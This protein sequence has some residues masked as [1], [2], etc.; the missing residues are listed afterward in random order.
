MTFAVVNSGAAHV[1]LQTANG[2][3]SG[4]I[5][6]SSA[7]ILVAHAASYKPGT[8]T[9]SDSK[10]NTWTKLT[11]KTA[12][13]FSKSQIA[14]AFDHGGSALV[15]G[16]GHTFTIATDTPPTYCTFNAAAFSGSL[17][18]DPINAQNGLAQNS[19]GTTIAPGSVS[20]AG[21]DLFITG[22]CFE[23]AA[24]VTIGS[25]FTILDQAGYVASTAFAGA[26]AWKESSSAENP[27]WTMNTNPAFD[28]A[29]TIA[30]FKAAAGGGG[31]VGPLTGGGRLVHGSLIRGGGLAA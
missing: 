17:T 19:T 31:L 16:S 14:Y 11:A 2:G 5:D 22:I 1:T 12:N 6:T 29:A 4:A 13:T 7:S 20:P 18:T 9:F 28:S 21:T 27:T 30:S 24:S 10:G 23:T 15:V 3:T 8:L 26:M 25:S